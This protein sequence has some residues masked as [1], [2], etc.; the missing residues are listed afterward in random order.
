VVTSNL[1]DPL[2]YHSFRSSFIYEEKGWAVYQPVVPQAA[3]FFD[4]WST[5][6]RKLSI[7]STPNYK[8]SRVTTF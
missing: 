4:E 1:S 2:D 5:Y 3:T 6:A 7:T 8:Y